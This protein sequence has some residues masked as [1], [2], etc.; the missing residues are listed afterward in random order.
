MIAHK[1]VLN[2]NQQESRSHEVTKNSLRSFVFFVLRDEQAIGSRSEAGI[3]S[4]WTG[5][6]PGQNGVTGEAENVVGRQPPFVSV[7]SVVEL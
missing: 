3:E 4:A 6:E 7:A 1:H 5:H 2:R